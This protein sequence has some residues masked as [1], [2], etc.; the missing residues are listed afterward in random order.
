VW[1]ITASSPAL[2]QHLQ[3]AHV[4]HL[5]AIGCCGSRADHAGPHH[6]NAGHEVM[7]SMLVGRGLTCCSVDPDV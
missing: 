7:A 3:P 4:R 2:R 6:K 1:H 5:R